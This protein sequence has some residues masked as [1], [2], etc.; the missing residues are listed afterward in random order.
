MQA[1]ISAGETPVALWGLPPFHLLITIR[2]VWDDLPLSSRIIHMAQGGQNSVSTG[3]QNSVDITKDVKEFVKQCYSK[4]KE[5]RII[6]FCIT[7]PDKD[8]EELLRFLNKMNIN[9]LT[10][11][12]DLI[13]AAQY[14]NCMLT[15][16]DY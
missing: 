11:F 9:N 10:L 8:R 4:S 7:I 12:P 13:G 14:C 6:L 1:N 3:G 2:K 15:I 16:D 5:D